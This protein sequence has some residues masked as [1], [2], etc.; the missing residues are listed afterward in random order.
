MNVS[1]FPRGTNILRSAIF[2]AAIGLSQALV[3]GVAGAGEQ[4]IVLRDYIQQEWKNELLT[5]PFSAPDGACQP[6]S[7]TL[8]GPQGPVPVQLSEIELWPGSQRVKSFTD[9]R[10]GILSPCW[11]TS[12]VGLK[13]IRIYNGQT[14]Y[15]R[16][17]PGGAKEFKAVLALDATVQKNLVLVAEDMKGGKAVTAA[18]RNNKCGLG[19]EYCGDHVNAGSMVSCHGPN[20]FGLTK[21]PGARLVDAGRRL[22]RRTA[23]PGAGGERAFDSCRQ[24][25]PGRRGRPTHQ[26]NPDHGSGRRGSPGRRQPA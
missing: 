9:L 18:R 26:P 3:A 12:D 21:P 22:G 8:A 20:H 25:R 11:V 15:R 13:E 10:T 17:L 23:G 7:V 19:I 24:D 14:L 1:V 6:E 2:M 16:F 5:Y 4:Q